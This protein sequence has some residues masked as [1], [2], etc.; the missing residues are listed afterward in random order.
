[1]VG[2]VLAAPALENEGLLA[3]CRVEL[4]GLLRLDG[5]AV[6]R[7]LHDSEITVTFPSKRDQHGDLHRQITPLDPDLD[8]SIRAAVVA[9]YIAERAR[10]GRRPL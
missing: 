9:A 5:L 10:A 4:A 6:R 3:W 8:R 7:R 1:M 2:V